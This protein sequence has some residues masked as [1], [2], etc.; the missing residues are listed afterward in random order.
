MS[1][2]DYKDPIFQHKK[3]KRSK[4]FISGNKLKKVNWQPITPIAL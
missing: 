4:Y 1:K 2:Q 3:G